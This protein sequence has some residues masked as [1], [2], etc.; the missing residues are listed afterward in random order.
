M[1]ILAE[2]IGYVA[3]FCVAV[4]FLPQTLQTIKS[5]NVKDLSLV[6]YVIYCTGV[7]CWVLYGL[8]LRSVQMVLFNLISLFFA[9]AILIMIIKYKRKK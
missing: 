8:Y 1:N 9:S 6:S 3:G 4:C 5:K 2:I 7:I